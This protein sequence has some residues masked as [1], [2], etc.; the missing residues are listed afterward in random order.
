[1]TPRDDAL[2]WLN[3]RLQYERW[4]DDLH[5]R[6]EATGSPAS[7]APAPPAEAAPAKAA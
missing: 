5:T 7:L 2:A 1:M 6:S 3:G 4:L